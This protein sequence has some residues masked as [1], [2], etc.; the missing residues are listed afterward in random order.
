MEDSSLKARMALAIRV[1]VLTLVAHIGKSHVG[2]L[3]GGH[4]IV[5]RQCWNVPF[6]PGPLMATAP[7][8]PE[9]T[10]KIVEGELASYCTM[11]N[12]QSYTL[13]SR[14]AKKPV[15]AMAV[16]A[17]ASGDSRGITYGVEKNSNPREGAPAHCEGNDGDAL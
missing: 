13:S 8:A 15:Y 10:D 4:R 16:V 6:G 2:D 11:S 3:P 9:R 12:A 7:G 14:E 17:N 1:C 5:S